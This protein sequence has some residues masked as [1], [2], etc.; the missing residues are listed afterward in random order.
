MAP[1]PGEALNDST[2]S[3]KSALAVDVSS[4]DSTFTG[5]TRAIYIGT[6][7]NLSVLFVGDSAPVTLSNLSSGF[8]HPM[9]VEKVLAA[10]TT[11]TGIVAGF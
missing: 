2:A 6:S 9:Q 10:G 1:R 3:I 7:G 4:V 5:V 8:W 11:A